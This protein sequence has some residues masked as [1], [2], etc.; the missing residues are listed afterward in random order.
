MLLKDLVITTTIDSSDFGR[1]LALS[2]Y[3]AEIANGRPLP[4]QGQGA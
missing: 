2:H 3:T 4:A 1:S